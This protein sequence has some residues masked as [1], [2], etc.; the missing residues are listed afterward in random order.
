MVKIYHNKSIHN[1]ISTEKRSMGG[2]QRK[3]GA[4]SQGV[5][6]PAESHRRRFLHLASG[7]HNTRAARERLSAQGLYWEL[8]TQVPSAWH[9]PKIQTLGRKAGISLNHIICTNSLGPVN[10]LNSLGN[11]RN[12]PRVHVSRCQPMANR[13][14]FLGITVVGLIR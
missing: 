6:A 13:Q 2:V 14:V 9:T 12:P 3:P 4:G 7:C 5:P 8:I 1:K 10:H 11:G